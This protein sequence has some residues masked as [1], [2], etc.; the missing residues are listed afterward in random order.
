MH[1]SV[2]SKSS[3]TKQR[4]R[5]RMRKESQL[6]HMQGQILSTIG[7]KAEQSSTE[8]R[9]KAWLHLNLKRSVPQIRQGK[10]KSSRLR[11]LKRM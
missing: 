10:S 4:W 7:L 11:K 6:A 3:S 1:Y 5:R 8:I 9:I 2:A